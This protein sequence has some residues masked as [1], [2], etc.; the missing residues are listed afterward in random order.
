M[1]EAEENLKTAISGPEWLPQFFTL[2][3]ADRVVVVSAAVVV[4]VGCGDHV[5]F[6]TAVVVG[7]GGHV[8][9]LLVVM[10]IILLLLLLLLVVVIMLLLLLIM[11]AFCSQL[12]QRLS[13]QKTA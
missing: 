7:C 2:A 3:L 6:A 1:A 9:L 12:L 10:V 5:V 11:P 8:V 4:A 13:N